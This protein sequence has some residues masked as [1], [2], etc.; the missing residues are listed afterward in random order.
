MRTKMRFLVAASAAY[1]LV[2][3]CTG[4]GDHPTAPTPSGSLQIGAGQLADHDGASHDPSTPAAAPIPLEQAAPVVAHMI[5]VFTEDALRQG[6]SRTGPGRWTYACPGGG[7]VRIVLADTLPTNQPVVLTA[8]ESIWTDCA[9]AALLS[10]VAVPTSS[11]PRAH[12][13][14]PVSDGGWRP[15]IRGRL[16]LTGTWVRSASPVYEVAPIGIQGSLD[17]DEI[18]AVP[19]DCSS[20]N[21][22][23]G[24]RGHVGG[25]TVGSPDTAPPPN[26]TPAPCTVNGIPVPCPPGDPTPAPGALNL[27]GTWSIAGGGTLSITH[28]GSV[29]ACAGLSVT[30]VVSCGGSVA[31]NAVGLTLVQRFVEGPLTITGTT[32]LTLTATNNSMSGS[33]VGTFECMSSDPDV[34]CLPLPP[35]SLPATLTRVN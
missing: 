4:G 33:G 2:A 32:V 7:E 18:G 10:A 8:T 3:A 21:T 30:H 34:P 13:T 29:I 35:V 26:P 31:G 15:R 27:T 14:P 9:A 20:T 17:V 24:C 22:Q 28:T 23:D 19:I 12:T 6:S 1:V 11:V 16:V 5:G 25:V